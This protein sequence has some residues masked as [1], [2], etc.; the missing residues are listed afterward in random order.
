MSANLLTMRVLYCS[1][2]I[3]RLG[4]T[5]HAKKARSSL[6][7]HLIASP[8]EIPKSSNRQSCKARKMCSLII[9]PVDNRSLSDPSTRGDGPSHRRSLSL[10]WNVVLLL[11]SSRH[12]CRT[13]PSD[14]RTR[15]FLP[16]CPTAASPQQRHRP[17]VYCEQFV[18]LPSGAPLWDAVPPFDP[19]C[20]WDNVLFPTDR[21]A[22]P[23]CFFEYPS[24]LEELRNMFWTVVRHEKRELTQ[25][26]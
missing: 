26:W 7:Q 16:A 10:A 22:F 13:P 9:D 1:L 18:R 8:I 17:V 15:I 23:A 6:R 25:L 3:H 5:L 12:R 21:A 24:L 2:L 11:Q 14:Q 20:A 4:Y 19:L